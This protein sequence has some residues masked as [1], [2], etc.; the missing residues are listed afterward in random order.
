[1]RIVDRRSGRID[2]RLHLLGI[3]VSDNERQFF[4]NRAGSWDPFGPKWRLPVHVPANKNSLKDAPIEA[5]RIT[6]GRV[7]SCLKTAAGAYG[8]SVHLRNR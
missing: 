5:L 3:R 7:W 2:F 8:Y 1:M 4:A 6:R